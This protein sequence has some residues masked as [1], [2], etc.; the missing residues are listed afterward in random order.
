VF[1]IVRLVR[2][3]RLSLRGVVGGAKGNWVGDAGGACLAAASAEEQLEE[4]HLVAVVDKAERRP[5]P[6]GC[7]LSRHA[8][9]A[10]SCC[11]LK[12]KKMI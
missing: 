2:T 4:W 5:V 9:C 11:A 12:P 1:V 8:P 7:A 6:M 3:R 10:V